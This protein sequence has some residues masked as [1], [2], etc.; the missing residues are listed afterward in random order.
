MAKIRILH[1]VTTILDGPPLF[2]WRSSD[3]WTSTRKDFRTLLSSDRIQTYAGDSPFGPPSFTMLSKTHGARISVVVVPSGQFVCGGSPWPSLT[4][5]K[6]YKNSIRN[7]LYNANNAQIFNLS[8]SR[9]CPYDITEVSLQYFRLAWKLFR[10]VFGWPKSRA[11]LV[12]FDDPDFIRRALECLQGMEQS[13]LLT[14]DSLYMDEKR[15]RFVQASPDERPSVL[16][17]ATV[18]T[19]FTYNQLAGLRALRYLSQA[20]GD[21]PILSQGHAMIRDLVTAAYN[22]SL[23]WNGI[24]QD[25]CDRF[26]NCTQDIEIFKG[27]PFI[28][29][30]D[31]CEVLDYVGPDIKDSR[32]KNCSSYRL[33]IRRNAAI[34]YGTVDQLGDFGSYW[35]PDPLNTSS[36]FDLSKRKLHD[37]LL[38]SF[39]R[40]SRGPSDWEHTIPFSLGL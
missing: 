34:S 32:R 6:V 13:Q 20:N 14:N 35:G 9:P 24:I 15:P 30:K 2:P 11:Q 17:D 31:F 7:H 27:L 37:Y 29:I 4:L 25:R 26:S 28:D 23:G 3:I 5:S 21:L 12:D 39:R 38:C 8:L 36:R 16:C 1:K 10:P 19:L 18:R 22:G 40:G 33:W